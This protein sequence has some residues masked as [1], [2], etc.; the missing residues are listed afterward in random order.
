MG[1]DCA[2]WTAA[3]RFCP[4]ESFRSMAPTT[5]ALLALLTASAMS[6]AWSPDGKWIYLTAKTDEFHIWRQRFPDGEPEQLTFGPTSQEGIA[7]APDGKSFDYIRRLAG[8]T[9]WLH[10]KDGDHQVSSEGD[11]SLPQFS[12]DGR[13]LYFLMANGQTHGEELW[14]KD[15]KQRKMDQSPAGLCRCESY[16][17]SRDG[18]E[19]AFAMNDQS[20]HSNLWIAPPAIARLRVHISSAASKILPISCLTATWSS[21]QSKAARTFFIA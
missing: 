8:H 11:A 10:D 19:V 1:I 5:F 9:V 12:A 2:R 21:E 3:P 4:A 16:A 7:M 17:V 18:K 13:K 20:G 14:V 6:G 15:L